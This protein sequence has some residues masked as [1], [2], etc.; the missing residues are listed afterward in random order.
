MFLIEINRK[1]IG[2][3]EELDCV[4]LFLDSFYELSLWECLGV[5]IVVGKWVFKEVWSLMGK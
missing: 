5:S 4:G 1:I 3:M 2:L